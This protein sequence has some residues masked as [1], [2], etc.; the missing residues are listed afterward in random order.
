MASFIDKHSR[1][2]NALDDSKGSSCPVEIQEL[3]DIIKHDYQDKCSWPTRYIQDSRGEDACHKDLTCHE[4]GRWQAKT[5]YTII[6][7]QEIYKP[8]TDPCTWN[9]TQVTFVQMV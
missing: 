4:D 9:S 5:R 8:T 1:S 7:S 3:L 2:A 6:L